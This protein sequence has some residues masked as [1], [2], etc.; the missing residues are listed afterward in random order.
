MALIKMSRA[1]W[2]GPYFKEN[3]IL[4]NNSTKNNEIFTESR[5]SIIIP[6]LIGS[7]INVHNGKNFLKV[8]ITENMIGR[9]LGEFSPTRKRFSFK[10]LKINK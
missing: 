6:N 9:K 4:K 5:S 8:K 3:L 7:T 2:K 10:K 1:K